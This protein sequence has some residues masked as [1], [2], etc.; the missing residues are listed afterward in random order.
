MNKKIF[1]L[2][3]GAV[4]FSVVY[5]VQPY[6]VNGFNP[7]LALAVF[8]GFLFNKNKKWAFALPLISMFLSD[9]IYQ[10]LY[11]NNLGTVKGF[12][13]WWQIANYASLVAVAAVGFY[14]KKN[15]ALQVGIAGIAGATL[16]FIL[17][18]FFVWAEG[19]GYQHS[20][21]LTGLITC[22]IDG[23]P[24]YNY[25]LTSTLIFSA[26]LFG[27]YYLITNPSK[28]KELA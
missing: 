1:A 23:I 26:V 14:I 20:Y 7:S 21:T 10:F 22:Y 15:N 19:M 4:L 25:S 27:V 2:V 18:N 24:F 16:F 3:I 9:V 17:S 12:Y 6:R 5:R 11:I 8:T 13:G 28:E